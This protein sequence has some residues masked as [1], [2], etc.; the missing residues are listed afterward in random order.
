MTCS[1]TQGCLI[2]DSSSENIPCL[3]DRHTVHPSGN[4]LPH[5]HACKSQA[6][7]NSNSVALLCCVVLKSHNLPMGLKVQEASAWGL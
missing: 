7:R 5:L 6:S 4:N 3:S 2:I 1:A